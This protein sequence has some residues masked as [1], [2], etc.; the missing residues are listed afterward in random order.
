[1]TGYTGRVLKGE[2]PADMPILRATRFDLIINLTTAKALGLEIRPTL[3]AGADEVTELKGASSS[4][5]L[6][7]RRHFPPAG[8]REAARESPSHRHVTNGQPRSDQDSYL[9]ER[10][11]RVRNAVT[12]PFSTLMS[13]LVTSATRKSRSEPAAVSTAFRPASSHDFSLTP[14]TS[15]IR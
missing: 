3:L 10:A 8:A 6:A 14:T 1:M 9:N 4:R 7:A 12:F 2:K 11:T 13:I 5:S 15:T